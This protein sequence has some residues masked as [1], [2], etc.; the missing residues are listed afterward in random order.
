MQERVIHN[1]LNST[2]EIDLCEV[3]GQ[4]WQGK[5]FIFSITLFAVMLGGLFL[6]TQEQRFESQISLSVKNIPPFYMEETV[7]SDFKN[8]FYSE[9][10]FSRWQST[11]TGPLFNFDDI[12]LYQNLDNFTFLKNTDTQLISFTKDHKNPVILAI[13][14]DNYQLITQI[15]AYSKYTVGLLDS[16]YQIRAKEEVKLIQARL[17]MLG[18]AGEVMVE[19]LLKVDRFYLELSM[20]KSTI[21]IERPSAPKLV[22]IKASLL[23]ILCIFLGVLIASVIVLVKQAIINHRNTL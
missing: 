5:L 11:I 14:S 6:L 9:T 21:D 3:I 13:Y 15:Y 17:K 12:S 1:S 7:I 8:L 22:S 16:L 20:K 18:I 4:L 23:L 2:D 19:D 10:T